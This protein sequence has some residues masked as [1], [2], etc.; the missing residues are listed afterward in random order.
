M[1][2]AVGRYLGSLTDSKSVVIGGETDAAARR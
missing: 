1:M 2:R